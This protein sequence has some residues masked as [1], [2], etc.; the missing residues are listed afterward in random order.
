MSFRF[1]PV[2]LFFFLSALLAV[3]T[4]LLWSTYR[5]T[6]EALQV[7]QLEQLK[8]TH[9]LAQQDFIHRLEE[10]KRALESAFVA[11]NDV[12]KKILNKILM[13]KMIWNY[14]VSYIKTNDDDYQLVESYGDF[15]DISR[16]LILKNN[17]W[18]FEET[19]KGLSL[20]YQF[21]IRQ[22]GPNGEIFFRGLKAGIYLK[23]NSPLLN[24]MRVASGASAH[25][26][27]YAGDVLA[28]SVS[29]EEGVQ[30]VVDEALKTSAPV[31]STIDNI[32]SADMRPLRIHLGP[33][34][35]YLLTVAIAQ[36]EE[37][38]EEDFRKSAIL[39]VQFVLI[40]AIVLT[41]LLR[42][43]TQKSLNRLL[44]YL[45]GVKDGQRDIFYQPGPIY[46]FNEVG[47]VVSNM[48]THLSEQGK[49]IADLV[50]S[51]NSPIIAWDEKRKISLFNKAVEDVLGMNLKTVSNMDDVLKRQKNPVAKKAYEDSFKG[52][53]TSSLETRISLKGRVR[54][55]I[56]NLTPIRDT[57]QKVIGGVCQ[58]QDI[59]ERRLAERRLRLSS[60][61]FDSTAEA[62]MITDEKGLIIDVNT[63]FTDI[64]G[65]N[66]EDVIGQNPRMMKSGRHSQA[67]Y[68]DMWQELQERGIW[69]GEIWDRRKNGE[70][71][72][73]MLSIS[74]ARNESGRLVNYVAVFSDITGQKENENKLEQL[75]HFDPL[76][77]LPNRVLFQDRLYSAL[78]RAK[79]EKEH[80]AVLFVD[81]DR[82]KQINDSFGHRM[83]DLLLKEVSRR[84]QH[85]MREIDTVARL[86]GDEFTVILTDIVSN[87][88]IEMV[89]S[90]IVKSVGAPYF[91]EGHELFVSASVG[92]SVYPLDGDSSEDLMRHADVA[93]YQAKEKGR[94]N[95]QFFDF[96]MNENA[97]NK[98]SLANQLRI[99]LNRNLV[100]PHYQLKIDSR[101][102]TPVGV[103]ALARWFD[104][105]GKAIS[106][107]EF[108]PV[109]EENGL[110]IKLGTSIIQ[111]ACVQARMWCDMQF[112]FGTIAINLSAQQF[113]DQNLLANI[114]EA[115]E[116]NRVSPNQLEL[117]VTE[118]MMV[119]DVEGAINILN[120]IKEMG[121]KISID[122]FGTGYSSLS[123]LKRFPVDTLKIDRSFIRDLTRD[124]DD[125]AIVSAI[126]SLAHE[127]NIKVVAEGVENME[128]V[129]FLKSINCNIVQGFLYAKPCEGGKIPLVWNHVVEEFGK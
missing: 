36:G 92:I 93:M 42:T 50:G 1:T 12:E 19:S 103:E 18:V 85:S 17:Q 124:N 115:L 61:V 20:V 28:S 118:N 122:D 84:L 125:A 35:I 58:G 15:T 72:P 48:V 129:E 4:F 110:I 117:E 74:A 26:L 107:V 29:L 73:K 40:V 59:T 57:S 46:E 76:T 38:W 101:T 119:E 21:S 96:S 99:A 98:M 79:R 14:A 9:E 89:A 67:F 83:G 6:E 127:L 114:Q 43:L 97:V 68:E 22:T 10:S 116:D 30:V 25:Y 52:I 108:I 86:S 33:K 51:A 24:H 37:S 47:A 120:A 3:S 75:A 55:I 54:Y 87:E 109:A 32:F 23:E 121:L 70:E 102:G 45:S 27:I 104:D 66:R 81:L 91:F 106:P 113:R 82:F 126:V 88:D 39:G 53:A 128:Q 90:R 65:Y 56:W 100:V 63:A 8:R 111:S 2:V 77:G 112:D 34:G 13:D 69:R 5:D 80:M 64:T 95:Y 49:Y 71:F 44:T 31:F 7:F 11:N 94:N 16:K 62:I 60:K 123:Y 41:F 105:Y 78:A